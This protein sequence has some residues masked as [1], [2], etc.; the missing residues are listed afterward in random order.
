MAARRPN[1]LLLLADQHRWD[2]AGFA[3]NVQLRTPHLDA[4]ASDAVRYDESFCVYPVCT[5]S[6][7]SLLT[8]LYVHQHLG[9]SNQCTIPA[10]LAT[11]PRRLAAAGYRTACVGKQHFTPT[12]LDVGYQHMQL[13]EQDGDGRL[14][15]DYHRELRDHGLVDALD[16][17]DQRREFRRQARPEYWATCGAMTSDL[18]EEW[19]STTW[20]GERALDELETWTG[21]GNL[22]TVGFIKPHHPFD[23]PAPWDRLYDPAAMELLPGWTDATPERDHA[24]SAGY[25]PNRDLTPE[26][27]RRVTAYYYATISHLDHQVGRMVESL[28]RRGLYEDTLIVYTA[29]HGE[30]LGFHHMILKGNHPYEPLL[31]VP[32]VIKWPR[33]ERAG[34]ASRQMVCTLDLAPTLLR[35]AGLEPPPEMR[36]LDLANPAAE[37]EF[38]FAQSGRG[39]FY[40]ARSRRH[41]LLWHRDPR[42][43]CFFDLEAD[44]HELHNLAGDAARAAQV[45]E[46]R[47]AAARWL[48]FDAPAPI[49]LDPSA[50]SI[51]APNALRAE[52]ERRAAMLAYFERV[53]APHLRPADEAR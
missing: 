9:G 11:F 36:G 14:D 42:Q 43:T 16:V 4:L 39:Q 22:L 51:D 46:H 1:V 8:G 5:P 25:F 6:R 37:R 38:V 31:R 28:R 18:P 17:I 32:L 12:Y 52:P 3:G 15:D 29:D 53:A 24:L 34:T 30:F 50:R 47:E 48:A 21:E 44:P 45:A 19:H 33:G 13:A 20:I 10:G 2:C 7:Y 41:K 27:V 35:A 23:P 26:Q 49:H 40:A